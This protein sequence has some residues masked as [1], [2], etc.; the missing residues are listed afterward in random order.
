MKNTILLLFLIFIL[1]ISLF[2]Q[3]ESSSLSNFSWQFS[4]GMG[5]TFHYAAPVTIDNPSFSFL[6]NQKSRKALHI[7]LA[8]NQR[9][10]KNQ[11]VFL[12]VGVN[13]VNFYRGPFSPFSSFL[14]S[15][16]LSNIYYGFYAGH[17]FYFLNRKKSS[18]FISNSL[19]ND[20]IVES[21]PV[22]FFKG[23]GFL[24]N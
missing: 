17:Q 13:S 2:S 15:A 16:Y 23:S 5:K 20:K 14:T 22:T 21:S 3:Y 6:A 7:N 10:S 9:I 24:I 12:G 19:F 11:E 1:P 8:L 4:F 18:F